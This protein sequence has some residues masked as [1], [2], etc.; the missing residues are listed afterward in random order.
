MK[1]KLMRHLWQ[2]CGISLI[3]VGC[4]GMWGKL[5]LPSIAILLT[6]LC[7]LPATF[8]ALRLQKKVWKI[9][10]PIAGTLL[11]C[12]SLLLT[13]SKQKTIPEF[14]GRDDPPV[15][16]YVSR[17]GERYHREQRCAGKSPRRTRRE[18]A[19]EDGLKPCKRCFDN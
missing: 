5:I 3:L 2:I 16:V 13:P 6:G 17:S 18:Y 19:I 12:L 9:I 4:V 1:T 15:F 14:V 10:L 7:L 8:T 11:F